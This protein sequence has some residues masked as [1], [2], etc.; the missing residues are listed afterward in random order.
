MTTEEKRKLA[1]G[2]GSIRSASVRERGDKHATSSEDELQTW[3]KVVKHSKVMQCG[4]VDE[5]NGGC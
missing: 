3:V 1:S 2:I 4:M 5:S